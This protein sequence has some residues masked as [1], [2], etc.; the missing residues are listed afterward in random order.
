MREVCAEGGWWGR[1]VPVGATETSSSI[2]EIHAVLQSNA[3][4]LPHLLSAPVLFSSCRV[5]AWPTGR[6]SPSVT[7]LSGLGEA[8]WMLGTLF[9]SDPGSKARSH[10]TGGSEA[11]FVHC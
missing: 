11:V 9:S 10:L 7:L 3:N 6:G 4:L 1:P 8:A 5:H 2:P